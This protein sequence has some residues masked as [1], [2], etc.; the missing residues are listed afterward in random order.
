MSLSEFKFPDMVKAHFIS[1]LSGCFL[2]PLERK[3]DF[4]NGL[5]DSK[6]NGICDYA[7]SPRDAFCAEELNK[8]NLKL[9]LGETSGPL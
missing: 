5:V 8:L 1:L 7:L 9:G 4:S 3:C 2:N 6:V